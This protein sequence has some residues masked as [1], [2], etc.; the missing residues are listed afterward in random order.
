ML[1][2]AA[3]L[4]LAQY[5]AG[6]FRVRMKRCSNFT[7]L[8][9]GLT[10]LAAGTAHAAK[11]T[12]TVTFGERSLASTLWYPD[13][14]AVIRGVM[15][16]T[17]GQ[18]PNDQ[19]GDTRPMAENKF[20]QRFAE[21]IGFAIIGNQF[22]GTY[23]DAAMGPGQA[24]LDTLAQFGTQTKHPELANAPLLLEGFS[25]GGYFSITFAKFR[26]KRVIAF[27]LN[28]SG[29]TQAPLDP[30]FAAVP[31]VLFYGEREITQNLP[32]VIRALV[33]QGRQQHAL[34]AQLI[35]WGRGHEEGDVERVFIPFF[36]DM[37]AARYPRG[38][39]P[40]DGEL[41]LFPLDEKKGFLGDHSE[42]SIATNLPTIASFDAYTGDKT[43]ASWLPNEGIANLWRGFVTKTPIG[44]DAPTAE[45]QLDASKALSLSATQLA[46]DERAS[47][48]DGARELAVDVAASG[49]QAKATWMPAWGG[50][51]GIV[52]LATKAGVVTR[53]SRPAAIVLFGKDPPP[54]P[55][56]P[57]PSADPAGAGSG[58][59]DAGAVVG[60][61]ATANP[62]D[63]GIVAP[64]DAGVLDAEV[65]ED[66]GFDAA[67]EP[68]DA[69]LAADGGDAEAE[70]ADKHRRLRD[71][72]AVYGGCNVAPKRSP[73]GVATSLWLLTVLACRPR[74]RRLAKQPRRKCA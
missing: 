64:I 46:A 70:H 71:V 38:K 44:L 43:A 45:A 5:T 6:S 57:E 9:F 50:G 42:A 29:Y 51:R 66:A 60:G 23:T 61:G 21:S 40:L 13:N 1:P 25:N 26:P 52:A 34:W 72:S 65:V 17:G 11:A 10:L 16:L 56:Q 39:S 69:S 22:T 55:P 49:G 41:K 62:K 30:E 67:I 24:L 7:A 18:G 2:L 31:G 47:F 59:A 19:S 33:A 48:L 37:V 36:A 68:E 27:A 20:Y 53:T 35:H 28:K 8:A 63:A 74:R 73:L 3:A 4:G 58:A 54:G 12:L 15:V 14:L 32:S